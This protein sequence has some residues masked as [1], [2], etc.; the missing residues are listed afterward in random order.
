MSGADVSE[1]EKK[2]KSTS[3]KSSGN[4]VSKVIGSSFGNLFGSEDV[5]F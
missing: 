1:K 3:G 4:K 2:E 5:D